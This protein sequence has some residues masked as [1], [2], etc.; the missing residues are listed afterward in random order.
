MADAARPHNIELEQALLGAILLNNDAFSHVGGFLRAEHF[1]EP[2]HRQIYDLTA[3]LLRKGSVVTPFTLKTFLPPSAPEITPGLT[4]SQYIARL[5]TEATT[6]LNAADYGRAIHD[7]AVRRSL[8]AIAE[9]ITN[10]ARHPAPEQPAHALI[11]QIATALHGL[12]TSSS[13]A[14]LEVHDAGDD[15][16]L[17][18]PRGWLQGNQFCR[19]FLSSVVAPGS[20][21]KSALRYA[22]VLAQATGRPIAGFHVFVRCAV[23]LLSLEDDV[24]EM[25]RRIAAVRLYHQIDPCE[26]RGWLFYAAPK[27]LKLAEMR[28]G[29]RQ[30]G[31]LEGL[32]RRQIERLK[33]G[34]VV[35]DPF[36]KTHALEEND[37]GAMD[38]VCDLL[39]KIAIEYDIAIDA[40]H[41]AKKGTLAP[42]DADTGRGGSAIRDAGRLVYTLTAMSED[43]AK[44]YGIKESDRKVFVRL[45]NAKVNLVPGTQPAAWFRLIGVPLRNGDDTYPAGDEI[46]TV[47]PWKPPST[48]AGLTNDDLNAALTEIDAGLLD[49]D[50]K[51]TSQR[52]SSAPRA[53]DRAAWKVVQ[54]HC[55]DKTESQCREIIRTW[56][57]SGLLIEREYED[58]KERKTV[59]GLHVDNTKRPS[60]DVRD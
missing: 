11:A 8:I 19:R 54:K 33:P 22:E 16:D 10:A 17:P 2:L 24:D 52:Y 25:R 46:Q 43:E 14:A 6:V 7:L 60:N 28:D 38:F 21:G 55:P 48:W 9:E 50:G 59:K 57:K 30:L 44:M 41:H 32:L 31:Q 18:P 35:L 3:S 26:L 4:A 15:V 34:L 51:P 36:V 27:G 1:Y 5:A 56:C 45:D 47:E 53:K 58:K 29:S 40:P 49:T 20:T 42:G 23:L 37:N 13:I 39:A 12:E